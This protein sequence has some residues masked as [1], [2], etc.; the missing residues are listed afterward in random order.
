MT[1]V[2]PLKVYCMNYG[3]QEERAVAST[4]KKLAASLIGTTLGQL[5]SYGG[6]TRETSCVEAAMSDPGTVWRRPYKFSI[7]KLEWQRVPTRIE[8]KEAPK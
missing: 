7:P 8:T 1:R 5:R 6:E 3:G 4:S 2:V